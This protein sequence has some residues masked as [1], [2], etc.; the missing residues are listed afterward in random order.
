MLEMIGVNPDDPTT[1]RAFHENQGYDLESPP[2]CIMKGACKGL[3]HF[4]DDCPNIE[5]DKTYYAYWMAW[6]FSAG[7]FT[8]IAVG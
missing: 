7:T 6:A 8:A 5:S 4:Y 2:L 1:H 3:L